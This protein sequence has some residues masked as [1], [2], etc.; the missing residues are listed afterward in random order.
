MVDYLMNL[1]RRNIMLNHG[2][3]TS[4]S[5]MSRSLKMKDI[6]WI[7]ILPLIMK[8]RF[9]CWQNNLVKSKRK[10]L[11]P[12]G[13]RW[14]MMRPGHKMKQWMMFLISLNFSITGG[15]LSHRMMLSKNLYKEI[16]PL[17]P[18]ILVWLVKMSITDSKPS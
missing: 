8:E 16:N 7:L 15:Q 17:R 1:L 11:K 9:R 14:L 18:Y 3:S 2:I 13:L 6:L 4:T 10:T 5:D 12:L